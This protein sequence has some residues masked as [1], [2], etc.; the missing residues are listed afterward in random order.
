MKLLTYKVDHFPFLL[1]FRYACH[2]AALNRIV[3]YLNSDFAFPPDGAPC[4]EKR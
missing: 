1:L 2:A 4:V 3:I